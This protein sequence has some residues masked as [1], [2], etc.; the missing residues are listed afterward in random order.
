MGVLP[1]QFCDGASAQS[2]G[3]DGS[4]VYHITA[5]ENNQIRPK[6]GKSCL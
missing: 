4:E 3:L 2:L 1:L 6:A 5:L